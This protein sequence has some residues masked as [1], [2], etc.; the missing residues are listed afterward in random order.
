[1]A[2]VDPR[3]HATALD[4]TAPLAAFVSQDRADQERHLRIQH[5]FGT[6]LEGGIRTARGPDGPE[7]PLALVHQWWHT[8]QRRSVTIGGALVDDPDGG[9]R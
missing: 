8:R 3:F 9:W 6:D 2:T 1:M 7:L 4:I 5:Y